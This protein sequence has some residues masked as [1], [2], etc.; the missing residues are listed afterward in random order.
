MG[1]GTSRLASSSSISTCSHS[2]LR[3]IQQQI[4][5]RLAFEIGSKYD[6]VSPITD[7]ADRRPRSCD[8]LLV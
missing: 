3:R 2:H 4:A 8:K 6:C 5:R 1:L 7:W